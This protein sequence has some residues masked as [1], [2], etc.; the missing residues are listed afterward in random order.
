ML[1]ETPPTN[2]PGDNSTYGKEDSNAE[3]P[4]KPID[5][6]VVPV[7]TKGTKVGKLN[8]LIQI[9]K[10]HDFKSEKN[11]ITFSVFF[12]FLNKPIARKVMFR[13]RVTSKSRR[14]RSMDDGTKAESVPTTCNL[15]NTTL[16]DTEHKDG[17]K[18]DYDCSAPTK[19]IDATKANIS[20]NTDVDMILEDKNGKQTLDFNEINFK[21]NSSQEASCLQVAEDM[22]KTNVDLNDVE[23]IKFDKDSF[24]IKGKAVPKNV[25]KKDDKI[26]FKIQNKNKA[27]EIIIEEV[28]CTV[29]SIDIG[30][31]DAVLDCKGDSN[32]TMKDLHSLI[33]SEGDYYLS[34]NM[35][36]WQNNTDILQSG[37]Y[38]KEGYEEGNTG[39]SY[40]YNNI[41]NKNNLKGLSGG[42]IAG[43]VIACVVAIAAATIAAIMLKK[44]SPPPYDNTTLVDF[45]TAEN[46]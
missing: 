36:D 29:E 23:R 35:K 13:L 5:P 1:Q 11:K 41:K 45:K 6:T 14:L 2:I 39:T 22:P 27:G 46:I 20:L 44:P 43:I 21:G 31:G 12:F 42:A 10:F 17:Q 19:N 18:V 25:L 33:G 34:L 37:K 4:P 9:I 16:A 7:S 38:Y 30:S 40:S 3:E 15:K 26:P 28:T 24:R 32:T 8:S